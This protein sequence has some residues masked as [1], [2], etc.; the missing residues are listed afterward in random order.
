MVIEKNRN[1][2]EKNRNVKE[3]ECKRTLELK[4]IR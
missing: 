2:K 3:Q 4:L 1:V